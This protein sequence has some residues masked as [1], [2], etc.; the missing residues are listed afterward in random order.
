MKMTPGVE[1][2]TSVDAKEKFPL[3][4]SLIFARHLPAVPEKMSKLLADRYPTAR[5]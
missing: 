4:Q 5:R 1:D 3:E 2:A